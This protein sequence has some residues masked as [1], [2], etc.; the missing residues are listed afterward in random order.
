MRGACDDVGAFAERVL[1]VR[2]DQAQHVGHVVHQEGVQAQF[3]DELPQFVYGF[4]VE[5]HALAQDDQFGP[6]LL[7]Q[8]PRC[9]RVDAVLVAGVH[10]EIHRGGFLGARVALHVVFQRAHRL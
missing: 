5:H 7:E 10:R 3:I 2:S 1:E 9:R 8:F 6:V 4:G